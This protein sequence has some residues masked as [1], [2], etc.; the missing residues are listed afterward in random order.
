VAAIG[1]VK[2]KAKNVKLKAKNVKLWS[3]KES[4]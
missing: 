4:S 3:S 2:L 1:N